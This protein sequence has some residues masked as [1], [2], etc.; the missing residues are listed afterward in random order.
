[1]KFL[2]SGFLI[3]QVVYIQIHMMAGLQFQ[4]FIGDNLVPF[5]VTPTQCEDLTVDFPYCPRG[6]E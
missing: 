4:V 6:Q 5:T 1:M 2:T 3:T